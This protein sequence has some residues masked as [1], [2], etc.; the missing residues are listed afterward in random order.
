MYTT[1]TLFSYY[2]S[3]WGLRRATVTYGKQRRDSVVGT[4][5]RNTD[6]LLGLEL[7]IFEREP[8]RYRRS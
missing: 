4:S 7:Q 5:T 3:Y 2:Y 8:L 1:S 6:L